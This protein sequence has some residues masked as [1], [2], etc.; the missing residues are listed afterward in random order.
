MKT[1]NLTI[2]GIKREFTVDPDMVLIDLLREK[3][4]LTGAKQS[5]D[6]K[7]Q[8][9]AC[10][11][12]VNG[13][14]VRS[15]LQKVEKLDN[16][17]VITVEGL[18]T[19]ENPHLIQEAFVLTGAIQCGFCT[20]GM[21]LATKALLDQN[22]DPDLNAIKKALARNLCRCTGYR[23][24][25]DAVRLAA[26]F[27]R[28]ETTPE[29]V[30]QSLGDKTF[31][32]SH[33][34]S[35]SILK[36]TGLAKFSNDIKV[37]GA[38]ELAVVHSTKFHAKI[39]SINMKE[40]EKMPGVVGIMI[41]EDIKGTNHIR[42][43]GADQPVLC[44]DVVRTLGD[45][46]AIVAA[47]TRDQARAAAAAVKV[48]Y[49]DL[50]VMMTPEEAMAEGAYQ[51]H[52][53]S[54]NLCYVQ[55]Q[56]KGDA[57]KALAMSAAMVE[58]TFTTQM[59]HQA[60]LEPENCLAYF[61]G[62]QL[63]VIGRSIM[64]HGHAGMISEAVGW[65]NVRVKEPFVGGHFGIALTI[66]TLGIP[67]AAAV[68]FKQAARYQPSLAESMQVTS[69]RHPFTMKVK[70]GAD[71][72]GRLTAY[73]NE[74]VIDKGAY[75]LSGPVIP[76][77]SLQMLSGSY[78]IPDV[79][80]K[81]ALSY[82]NNASGGA[83]RGA[84]P[85]QVAVALE[86]AMD[87]LAEKLNVDPLEF[88]KMNSLKIGETL[89][90]GKAAEQWP[91]PE[92]CDAIRPAYEKAKK[93]AAA[94]KQGDIKRGVG[95]AAYSFGVAEWGDNA[96]VSV[97]VDKDGGVTVYGAVA[98]PGEGNESMLKQIAATMLELPLNKVRIYTRDMDKTTHTG[99]AGGSRITYMCGGALVNAV[100]QLRKALKESGAET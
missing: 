51:I 22:P 62:D 8:C 95:I 79:Y 19:P 14:A 65:K 40:A 71:A 15:C 53:H 84:G 29:K 90:V 20:P 12:I 69:K 88:R 64:I 47:K 99:A 49:E 27:L 3:L 67:A 74:F 86:C 70:L 97:E 32:V 6:R 34:R 36:A 61:E 44:E 78:N 89:S 37:P 96:Q 45:P 81:A 59:N 24:I 63:I 35:S 39:K 18:G 68:H 60:A 7:G 16:A 58:A 57:E 98:D 31:G 42:M 93:E 54:P 92:L 23:K 2:N 66:S 91:F 82:T 77:R 13:K 52:P 55:P 100:E 11:V 75:F 94:Q 73:T 50:P 38:L 48:E 10:T 30:R 1:V 46:I 4:D 85:P 25:V 41:A 87:M 83:A 26:R 28:N 72:Q 56:V 5:C 43:V 80:A 33:P 9:G 21:I 17:E 76:I